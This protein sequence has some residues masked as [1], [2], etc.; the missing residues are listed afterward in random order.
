MQVPTHRNNPQTNTRMPG[1]T[2]IFL[3][4]RTTAERTQ[5]AKDAA[6]KD[7]PGG[8]LTSDLGSAEK[9]SANAVDLPTAA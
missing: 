7:T 4:P 1:F 6:S 8:I 2:P 3:T 5:A 9:Y